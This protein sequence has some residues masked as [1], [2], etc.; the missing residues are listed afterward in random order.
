MLSAS[1][2]RRFYEG[3]AATSRSTPDETSC[4]SRQR[5]RSAD[6]DGAFRHRT[7]LPFAPAI[8][9]CFDMSGSRSDPIGRKLS[10]APS[11]EALM[12]RYKAGDHAAF[13]ALFRRY[14][15]RLLQVMQYRL[16]RREDAH[17]LVQ[18]TFLQLHRSREDFRPDALLRPWLLTIALNLKRRHLRRLRH[19]ETPLD[20]DVLDVAG[21]DLAR[22]FAFEDEG[23][24]RAL[25][26]RLPPD[27]RRV[28]IL[29]WMEG[30]TFAEVAVAVG[31]SL[32][33]VKVRAHRGYTAIRDTF[34]SARD[35]TAA[36]RPHRSTPCR[37]PRGESV[38]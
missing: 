35:D 4:S 24:V 9:T 12:A 27:Q 32:S 38:A 15:P 17:D 18:Q 16:R 14:S 37:D 22:E 19:P 30:R 8:R 1:S 5:S 28:I 20:E 6:I 13:V 21:A 36:A 29:H 31:A 23:R 25:I 3:S 2:Y 11:D 7:M 26:D 33:A 10:R 34:M